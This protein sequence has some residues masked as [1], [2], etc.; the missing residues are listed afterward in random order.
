M[1]RWIR[2]PLVLWS[3]NDHS[4]SH[5]TGINIKNYFF[6]LFNI[7]M[8]LLN[9]DKRFEF[10]NFLT[11]PHYVLMFIW[12]LIKER[13]THGSQWQIKLFA[14][15]IFYKIRKCI[16]NSNILE[17]YLIFYLFEV[18]LRYNSHTIYIWYML[19]WTPLAVPVIS[20][21][22]RLHSGNYNTTSNWLKA[23]YWPTDWYSSLEIL[24]DRLHLE[25]EIIRTFYLF[26]YFAINHC[27]T[28][29]IIL[30]QCD[31]L[32]Q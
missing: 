6:L 8:T 1:I 11:S 21:H 14:I 22:R 27:V 28:K 5:Y 31:L 16:I 7:T 9:D 29:S 15:G 26:I 4:N 32:Y 20:S 10:F 25:I 12:N 13:N 23:Q 30:S 18:F 2:G 17:S 24:F 3:V 19:R